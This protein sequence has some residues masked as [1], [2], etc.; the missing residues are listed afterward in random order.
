MDVHSINSALLSGQIDIPR[1][2]PHRDKLLKA[3]INFKINFGLESMPTEPGLILIRGARQ[4]GKSTWIES[5]IYQTIVEFG[6]G[7]ALYLNGDLISDFKELASQVQTMASIFPKSVKIKRLF[8]DEITAIK[9][10]E[11]GLKIVIDAGLA[12]DILMVTTGSKATDLMR[13]TE[14]LPGR[15]GRL[16]RTSYLFTPVSFSDF[17]KC[18]NNDTI[19]NPLDIYCIGG[20]CPIACSEL[21]Q[22][23][24]LP[25]YIREMIRDWIFGEFAMAG[26]NR[27]SL[28]NTI[29]AVLTRGG[30]TI[31][32][33]K[34]SKEA[35]LANNTIASE[36]IRQLV[37]LMVLG[38]SMPFDASKKQLIPRK[39]GKLP[40][41]NILAASTF[42]PGAPSTPAEFQ[43]LQPKIKGIW[44]E[45]VVAQELWR[46]AAI[47]GDKTAEIIPFWQSDKHEIDFIVNSD[48]FIEVKS[49]PASPLEFTWFPAVFPNN[50]L[51]VITTTPFEA[52]FATGI[53]LE[54]FLLS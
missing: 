12:E 26:R 8:I 27:T 39:P 20:G 30:S 1:V 6:P 54:N 21:I 15:K 45:W 31:S 18:C 7:T 16:G 53:T 46:R 52:G 41:I 42:H 49:G 11:K 50:H 25:D 3:P 44:T 23:G 28:I 24:Q 35:G 10:W 17:K 40:F 51:T 19:I 13:G 2:F 5:A 36:Y 47:R 43:L 29:N 33:L 34:L 32:Q 4:Y 9:N 48:E 14:R 38:Q 37:E 22:T